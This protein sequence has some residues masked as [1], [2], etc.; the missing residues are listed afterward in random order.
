MALRNYPI[1]WAQF[2]WQFGRDGGV[3]GD[4]PLGVFMPINAAPGFGGTITY[5]QG[6]AGGGGATH[7]IVI[8]TANETVVVLP[9]G[10]NTLVLGT[11][12]TLT[13]VPAQMLQL[14]AVGEINLRLAVAPATGGSITGQIPFSI[15]PTDD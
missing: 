10:L 5:P 14:T 7:S 6:I 13:P 12:D 4:I 9:A 1:Y 3:V 11:T 15:I 2:N 8:I